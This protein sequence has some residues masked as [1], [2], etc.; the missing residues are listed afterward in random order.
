MAGNFS[1]VE[2][3]AAQAAQKLKIAL[4]RMSGMLSAAQAAQK[5]ESVTDKIILM[6]SAAQAAQKMKV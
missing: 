1:G 6:L 4:E 3:S 2:L 5:S